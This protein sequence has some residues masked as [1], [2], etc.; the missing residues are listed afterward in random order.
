MKSLVRNFLVSLFLI[1]A[2]YP[3]HL[4]ALEG[5][6]VRYTLHGLLNVESDEIAGPIHLHAAD[7]RVFILK[8][9][10]FRARALRNQWV[11]VE[12]KAKRSDAIEYLD[13]DSIKA[14]A[15]PPQFATQQ[16]YADYQQPA[17]LVSQVGQQFQIDGIRWN[18][19]QD[20]ATSTVKA[21][22]TWKRATI[23]IEKVRNVYIVAKPM[24]PEIILAH[25]M[26]VFTF[27]KGGFVSENGEESQGLTLSIE[28]GLPPGKMYGLVSCTKKTFNVVWNL[29]TWENYANLWIPFATESK[30]PRLT[31]Y[32]LHLD[33]AQKK[34]LLQQSILQACK[35][36]DGEFYHTTRNNCT[37][38]LMILLNSVLPSNKEINLWYVPNMLYDLHATV[39]V[40]V[41]KTLMRDGILGDPVFE[42]NRDYF[43]TDIPDRP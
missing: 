19:A 32:P 1:V 17:K 21:V 15:T 41:L 13:V 37:N 7:G 11:I 31:F 30:N 4:W 3:C 22:H 18:I 9:D 12:G 35:N 23:D 36:R 2:L 14:S 33:G 10:P 20:P 27:D 25:C 5:Y 8:M 38:N 24:Q 42:I 34:Q 29:T 40:A 26:F 16:K 39:P 43:V 28:A 6:G